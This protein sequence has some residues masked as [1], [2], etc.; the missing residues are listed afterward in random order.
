[1]SLKK[2]VGLTDVR[3]TGGTEI[4]HATTAISHWNGYKLDIGSEST[5]KI[6]VFATQ[7]KATEGL[8]GSYPSYTFEDGGYKYVILDEGDHL[9]IAIQ[10]V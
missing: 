10:K 7:N 3:I 8:V 2:A 4:G 6:L 1:M 5:P 9:D